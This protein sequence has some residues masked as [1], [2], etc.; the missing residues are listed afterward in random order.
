MSQISKLGEA[1]KPIKTREDYFQK[2]SQEGFFGSGAEAYVLAAKHT[3]PIQ[4][5]VDNVVWN[6]HDGVSTENPAIIVLKNGDHFD[7]G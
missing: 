5:H 1:P 4:F 2:V 6:I 7:V 3:L